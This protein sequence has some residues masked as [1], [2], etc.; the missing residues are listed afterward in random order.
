MGR[1]FLRHVL[2]VA[3]M[4]THLGVQALVA[5]LEGAILVVQADAAH[6][7]V[8]VDAMLPSE[9]LVEVRAAPRQ[10]YALAHALRVL[11]RREQPLPGGVQVEDGVAGREARHR[12]AQD[13]V[14][15]VFA[16]IATRRASLVKVRGVDELP[17]VHAAF[18]DERVHGAPGVHR[19]PGLVLHRRKERRKALAARTRR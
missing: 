17:E 11:L 19:P 18:F 3:Q 5:I 6:H 13:L 12:V 10:R 4:G 1:Q 15:R 9:V 8:H 2:R 16:S 7:P 14:P